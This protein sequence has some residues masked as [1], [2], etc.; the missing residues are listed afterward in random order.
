M[1]KV[2]KMEH[3]Y[4]GERKMKV[5]DTRKQA[6][7]TLMEMIVAIAVSMIVLA[8]ATPSF[9]SWMPTIRLTSAARQVASDLQVA[10][11][12]A[13][14]QNTNNTVTFNTTTGTYA[15]TLGSDSRDIGQLYPGITILSVSSNPVFTPRGTA[16]A[17]AEIKLNNG[18]AQKFVCVKAVGR[19][20][21][22][23]TTCT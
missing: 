23:D 22:Q 13:I 16:S 4:G 11:M 20:N 14:S 12:K 18:S 1:N 5:L 8:V 10:R 9:L 3:W 21:I 15:F 17:G 6:G 2:A 7:V 19:V